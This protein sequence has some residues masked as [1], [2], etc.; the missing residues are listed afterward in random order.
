MRA[1]RTSWIVALM[2]GSMLLA[3]RTGGSCT[4]E[5][6]CRDALGLQVFIVPEPEIC[7]GGYPDCPGMITYDEVE[8]WVQEKR[9]RQKFCLIAGKETELLL[10]HAVRQ[11]MNQGCDIGPNARAADRCA[12]V[13]VFYWP[14]AMKRKIHNHSVYQRRAATQDRRPTT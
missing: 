2:L 9:P 8:H 13:F 1:M 7:R 10:D 11:A 5:F 3:Q 14:H 6:P 4:V 12:A